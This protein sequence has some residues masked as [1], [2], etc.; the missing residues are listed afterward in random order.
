MSKSLSKSGKRKLH[1]FFNQINYT[2]RLEMYSMLT[3]KQNKLTNKTTG[4]SFLALL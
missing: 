3:H 4:R 1:N 2:Q